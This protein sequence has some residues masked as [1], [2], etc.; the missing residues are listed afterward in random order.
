MCD[1]GETQCLPKKTKWFASSFAPKPKTHRISEYE[2]DIFLTVNK[3]PKVCSCS[4]NP[5]LRR[6][7]QIYR[8]RKTTQ[9]WSSLSCLIVREGGDCI[10]DIRD[11]WLKNV[12]ITVCVNRVLCQRWKCLKHQQLT[13]LSDLTWPPLSGMHVALMLHVAK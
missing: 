3:Q 12:K 1:L 6:Q 2:C 13:E 10:R 7:F 4:P 11:L 9:H 5:A 8:C